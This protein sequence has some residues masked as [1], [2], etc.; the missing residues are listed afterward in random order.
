MDSIN[1]ESGNSIMSYASNTITLGDTTSQQV[2][3]NILKGL[4]ELHTSANRDL[5]CATTNLIE[6]GNTADKMN[7]FNNGID[8]TNPSNYVN[9]SVQLNSTSGKYNTTIGT[10][11][12]NNTGNVNG[13]TLRN[14]SS[15][16]FGDCRFRLESQDSTGDGTPV[17]E[18]LNTATTKASYIYLIN[19]DGS[20][21]LE[22]GANIRFR[23]AGAG[24]AGPLDLCRFTETA[25]QVFLRDADLRGS[26]TNSNPNTTVLPM[27]DIFCQ[28]IFAEDIFCDTVFGNCKSFK[29]Q[30]PVNDKK[31]LYHNAIEAPQINNMYSGKVKLIDGKATIDMDDNDSYKMT[32]GTFLALNR[33]FKIF[34]SNNNDFDRVIGKLNNSQLIITCENNKSNVEVD[35][36]V[37]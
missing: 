9:F 26:N 11:A 19:T 31:T 16:H 27:G 10:G 28:D 17:I 18:F 7:I 6:L 12:N 5:M 22:S 13:L 20:L 23:I 30:H 33:D 21:W 8:L 15:S 36:L 4:S 29:I 25:D 34:V 37:V 2:S 3:I 14:T 24:S 32:T 35:W 1:S